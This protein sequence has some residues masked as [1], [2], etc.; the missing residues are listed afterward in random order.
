LHTI[1]A[2]ELS[3]SMRRLGIEPNLLIKRSPETLLEGKAR[4]MDTSGPADRNEE[5]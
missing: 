4:K 2:G 3:K 5:D 1:C